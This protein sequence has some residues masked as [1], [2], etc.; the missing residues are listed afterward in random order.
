MNNIERFTTLKL[1][2][3]RVAWYLGN[4]LSALLGRQ[5]TCTAMAEDDSYWSIAAID[6]R[7]SNSEIV[8]LIHYVGGNA[9]MVRSC[10]PPDSNS[11]KS[12][13][14][15]LCE[16]LLKHVLKIDWT[17]EFV[18]KDA[19]WLLGNW[20]E[21]LKL[22]EVDE[23]LIFIDSR[24]IDCSKLMPK[25]EFVEKLFDDGGTFTVLTSLCEDNEV[26]FGTP[27]YW[28]H[29]YTDGLYNGCYFVLVREGVL[30][31]S[32]DAIDWEDHEVFDRE[33]VRLCDAEEMR[34]F[35]WEYKKRTGEMLDTLNAFLF[36]LER[37][38][39]QENA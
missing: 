34:N 3:S 9:T 22:P 29:P 27:L 11:S 13:G 30:I 5:I 28:M 4:I 32:Y 1:E 24:V 16:A 10:I 38:E 26:A 19:L 31:L 14:M 39:E 18:T 15:D 8:R 7:F 33:S 23:N 12:L 20:D 25:D 36:F 37:K 17:R 35:Y 2:F 21:P 6:D